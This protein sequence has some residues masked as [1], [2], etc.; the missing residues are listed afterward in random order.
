MQ[1]NDISEKLFDSILKIAAEEALEQEMVEMVSCEELNK[2]YRP[3]YNLDKK[4]KRIM[5]R[6]RIR[7][8]LFV[9]GKISGKI[10]VAMIIIIVISST[11]LL[12]VK[13]TRNYIFNA[14]IRWQEDHFSIQ[15]D[16]NDDNN[17]NIIIFRPTYV[18]A[19]FKEV[20]ANVIGDIIKITYKNE[21]EQVI[22]LKQSPSQVSHILADYEDK[23]YIETEIN[24]NKAYVFSAIED[25]NNNVI[26][27]Y[28]GILFN[29]TSELEISELI[30]MGES[31]LQ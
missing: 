7:E 6:Y 17:Y 11:V 29:I 16:S 2:E 13:A 21:N 31:I 22:T 26:W 1:R 8:K 18:P 12:S 20:S 9:W 24:G 4:I 28:D 3:S 30:M 27:E 10:A 19:G 14:V 23:S 15:H 5:L 25:D